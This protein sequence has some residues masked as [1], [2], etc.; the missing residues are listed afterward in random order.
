[1]TEQ[2]K[3]LEVVKETLREQEK[4]L[5]L[6]NGELLE[7]YELEEGAMY[8]EGGRDLSDAL[9]AII[10]KS[11]EGV[12]CEEFLKEEDDEDESIIESVEDNNDS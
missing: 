9:D 2:D 5:G 6:K 11:L 7:I 1:M 4:L 12:N 8:N 10:R 3:R